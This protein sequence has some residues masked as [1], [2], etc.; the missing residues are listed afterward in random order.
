MQRSIEQLQTGLEAREMEVSAGGGAVKVR[1]TAGG[2][3]VA[4]QLDPEFLKEDPKVVSEAILAAVQDAAR[5][6]KEAHDGEMQKLT[7]SLQMPGLF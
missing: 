2:R 6:A 7:S 1:I 4:L 3:F 5:Q